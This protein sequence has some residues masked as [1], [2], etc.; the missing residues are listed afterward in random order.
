M[1]QKITQPC[2]IRVRTQIPD[3]GDLGLVKITFGNR[4]VPALL[5]VG[6]RAI[7]ARPRPPAVA[8]P[9]ASAVV[10]AAA[11]VGAVGPPPTQHATYSHTRSPW[12]F[13]HVAQR[14]SREELIFDYSLIF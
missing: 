3:S 11:A 9:A 6:A 1:Y 13:V 12:T 2:G 5:S 14:H 4:V 8:A 10:A 7:Q